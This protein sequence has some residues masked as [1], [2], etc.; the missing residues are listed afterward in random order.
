METKLSDEAEMRLIKPSLSFHAFWI[1]HQH[2]DLP[3]RES[4]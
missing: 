3:L 4:C 1:P 2:Q